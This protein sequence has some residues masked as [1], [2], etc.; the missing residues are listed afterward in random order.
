MHEQ[1]FSGATKENLGSVH[2]RW[3]DHRD[4]EL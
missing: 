3:L 2:Y 1:C 4:P